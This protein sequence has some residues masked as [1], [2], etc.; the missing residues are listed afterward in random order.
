MCPIMS[1]LAP[2][3]GV[4][5]LHDRGAAI[6]PCSYPVACGHHWC[7]CSIAPRRWT[8]RVQ[9]HQHHH[10][11]II[12][13]I[14]TST[15]TEV[16]S[17]CGHCNCCGAGNCERPRGAVGASAAAIIG[18]VTIC[19]SRVRSITRT[20][21]HTAFS[22]S[23]RHTRPCQPGPLALPA[24]RSCR[25]AVP[26][27][28]RRLGCF[29]LCAM[30]IQGNASTY[31]CVVQSFMP[32]L[33]RCV[34]AEGVRAMPPKTARSGLAGCSLVSICSLVR[35]CFG[36][37]LENWQVLIP[38]R[39]RCSLPPRWSNSLV[40]LSFSPRLALAPSHACVAMAGGGRSLGVHA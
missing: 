18:S 5:V 12:I 22:G 17:G 26:D 28:P 19:T 9:W 11:I 15:T 35:L 3:A 38:L 30:M 40:R 34:H 37:G 20:Q 24:T 23:R 6:S 8:R 32:M 2:L 7:Q 16:N 29:S 27:V 13:V 10:Y 14:V 25:R 4:A 36:L 1:H 33:M 21:R 31:A 39:K